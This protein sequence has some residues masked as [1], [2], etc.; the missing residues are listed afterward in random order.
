ME[1]WKGKPPWPPFWFCRRLP[2]HLAHTT[3]L[4]P[5]ILFGCRKSSRCRQSGSFYFCQVSFPAYTLP[6]I[7]S[8]TLLP[9]FFWV[10]CPLCSAK[11]WTPLHP[12]PWSLCAYPGTAAWDDSG[13]SPAAAH[14]Q[15]HLSWALTFPQQLFSVLVPFPQRLF[16]VF[17]S[18]VKLP[19]SPSHPSLSA[20][21]CFL[22]FWENVISWGLTICQAPC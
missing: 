22:L 9:L 7:I 16:T 21:D 10:S 19:A 8:I 4:L 17:I 14:S 13:A 2:F 5:I 11:L 15:S 1:L 12:S 20:K 18:F 3:F 6:S